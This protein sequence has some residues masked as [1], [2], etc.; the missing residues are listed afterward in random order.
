MSIFENLENLNVSEECFNSIMDIVEE[1]IYETSA[2]KIQAVADKRAHDAGYESAKQFNSGEKIQKGE[3]AR[4]K[5][6]KFKD[7]LRKREDRTGEW[8]AN[9]NKMQDSYN[10]GWDEAK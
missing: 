1:I 5:F 4:G 10:K 2:E 6:A 9:R 7:L 3:E 8:A